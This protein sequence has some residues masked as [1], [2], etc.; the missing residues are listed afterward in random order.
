MSFLQT[1]QIGQ[2]L[3]EHIFFLDQGGNQGQDLFAGGGQDN[4]APVPDKQG[5]SEFLF[6]LLYNVTDGRWCNV[7]KFRC[8]LKAAV[9]Y[10]REKYTVI[11]CVHAFVLLSL[12]QYKMKIIKV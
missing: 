5:D 11:K 7:V 3:K 12:L 4:T 2:I 6:H 9:L 10:D 1:V 8:F